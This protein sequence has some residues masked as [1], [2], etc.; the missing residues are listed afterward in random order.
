VTT[1]S[2]ASGPLNDGGSTFGAIV[3]IGLAV[4]VIGD[5]NV[6]G[7]AKVDERTSGSAAALEART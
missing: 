7:A 5:D 1:F 2:G 4:T 3:W 6:A